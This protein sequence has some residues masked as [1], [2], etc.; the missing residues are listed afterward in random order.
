MTHC[1]SVFKRWRMKTPGSTFSK[2][3]FLVTIWAIGHPSQSTSMPCGFEPHPSTNLMSLKGKEIKN[4][5]FLNKLIDLLCKPYSL[6]HVY[7][8]LQSHLQRDREIRDTSTLHSFS[9]NLFDSI[10][11]HF[12]DLKSSLILDILFVLLSLGLRGKLWSRG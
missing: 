11:T 8:Q 5:F 1:F 2:T 3:I 4:N 12:S 6:Q 9:S 10:W 7:L